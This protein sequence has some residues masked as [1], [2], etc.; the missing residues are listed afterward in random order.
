MLQ[1]LI[2]ESLTK[3]VAMFM[4]CTL[5]VRGVD[6]FLYGLHFL[7]DLDLTLCR[8]GLYFLAKDLT[9]NGVVTSMMLVCVHQYT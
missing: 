4:W 3:L 1:T 2:G 8:N 5:L 9:T 7:L 6:L